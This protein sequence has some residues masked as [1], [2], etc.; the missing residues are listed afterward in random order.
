MENIYDINALKFIHSF[1]AQKKWFLLVYVLCPLE[2]SMFSAFVA[3]CSASTHYVYM[4]GSVFHASYI[5][6][7]F[8]S[9]HFIS[10]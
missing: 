8:L 7:N 10:Y 2:K 3:Q 6:T 4:V 9:T 1:M 5:L